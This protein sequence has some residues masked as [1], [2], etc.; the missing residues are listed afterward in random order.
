MKMTLTSRDF[1]QV[2]PNMITKKA[3]ADLAIRTVIRHDENIPSIQYDWYPN[4]QLKSSQEA[5]NPAIGR[6]A[7]FELRRCTNE[8]FEVLVVFAIMIE[9]WNDV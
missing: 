5:A 9:G 3:G 6:C 4:V 2:Y 1:F 8:F 7:S